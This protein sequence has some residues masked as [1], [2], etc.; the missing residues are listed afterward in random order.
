MK[1]SLNK[2]A[3]RIDRGFNFEVRIEPPDKPLENAKQEKELQKAVG[4]IQG[5]SENM[6]YMKL[7]GPPILALPEKVESGKG[8][9]SKAK[10]SKTLEAAAAKE[11]VGAK[12]HSNQKEPGGTDSR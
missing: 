5:A 9:K 10:K 7:E 4:T 6:Q 12:E 8:G 2:I 11:R 3:N 1:I